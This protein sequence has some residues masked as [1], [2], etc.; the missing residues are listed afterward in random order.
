[1]PKG[2]AEPITTRIQAY[3][4]VG[5]DLAS[6]MTGR[7]EGSVFRVVGCKLWSCKTDWERV[8]GGSESWS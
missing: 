5:V 6:R 3:G 4:V 8:D 7:G 1:V 2:H